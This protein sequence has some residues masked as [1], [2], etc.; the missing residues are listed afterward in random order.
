[1]DEF[2]MPERLNITPEAW[3]ATPVD[4]KSEII[5]MVKELTAGFDKYA[6][7]AARDAELVEFHELAATGGTTLAAALGRYVAMENMIKAD[8]IA[9]IFK[10]C[11]NMG[12]DPL[13]VLRRLATPQ[14]HAA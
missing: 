11:E 4:I 10:I 8:F 5:R 3:D 1:M 14:E 7:A 12:L 2:P 9:G 13:D 6:A